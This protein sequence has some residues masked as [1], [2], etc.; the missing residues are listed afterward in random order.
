MYAQVLFQQKVG[1]ESCCLTYKIPENMELQIGQGVKAPI[2]RKVA[3]GI[4]W[5]IT[6]QKPEF[7]TV[8]IQEV[9]SQK[10]LLSTNQIQLLKWI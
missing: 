9:I 3:N 5:H 6:E 2:R 4:I 10:P 8:E 1:Q 7:K